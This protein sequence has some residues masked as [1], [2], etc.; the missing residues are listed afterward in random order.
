[1]ILTAYHFD[2]LGQGTDLIEI[3]RKW[4]HNLRF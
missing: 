4:A 2:N 1:M 3:N